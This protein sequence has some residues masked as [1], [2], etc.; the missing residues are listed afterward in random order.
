MATGNEQSIE[1]LKSA[2]SHA[3]A[4]VTRKVNKLNE[5]MSAH[6]SVEAVKH[7]ATEL[8]EIMQEFKQAHNFGPG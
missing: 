4:K 3:K 6:E 1:Q 7:A 5:L 8:N 2:R